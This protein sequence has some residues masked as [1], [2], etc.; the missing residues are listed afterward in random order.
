MLAAFSALLPVLST[1]AENPVTAPGASPE[2]SSLPDIATP[3]R[4]GGATIVPGANGVSFEGRSNWAKVVVSPEYSSQTQLGLNVGA[5]VRLGESAALG[6]LL[7]GGERKSEV[8]FNAGFDL[9]P[10]QR[11]IFSFGQLRQNLEYDFVSGAD[12]ARMTQNSG[13]ISYQYLLG[14]SLLKQVELTAYIAD[15]RSRDLTDKTYSVDTATVYELWNDP[16]RIAGGRVSGLQGRIG[17][18][19]L[20]GSNVKLSLG[21][22]R[23]VYDLLAG[24]DKTTRLTGGIEWAQQL[25]AGYQWMV[26]A[27][28]FAA[29][30]HYNLG[31]ERRL[32]DGQQIGLAFTG[33]QGRDGA[34]DDNR[35]QLTWSIGFGATGSRPAGT[36]LPSG[37][38]AGTA[39]PGQAN[40]LLDQVAR[41]PTFLPSQVIAK[42]DMSATPTRLVAIDKVGLPA[43][44]SIGASGDIS[45]PLGVAVTAISSI[46]RNAAAFTNSGQFALSGNNLIVRP[47]QMIQPA[48]GVP[49]SYV[50]TIANQDG[51]TTLVTVSA[52][53]GSV[54]IDSVVVTQV[55]GDSTAPSLTSTANLGAANIGQTVSHT[56]T[57]DEAI[58]AVSV[59]TVPTGM[60]V[61]ATRSGSSVT[62]QIVTTASFTAF[63]SVMIPVTVSDGVPN[64]RTVNV[65]KA[66]S[67]LAL[68]AGGAF[69]GLGDMTVS[70]ASGNSMLTINAGGVTDPLGRTITYSASG[71]FKAVGDPDNYFWNGGLTIDST[72]GTI[73]G[74]YD[75]FGNKV[76]NVTVTATNGSSSISKSFV[77]T[78]RDDG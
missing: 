9:D 25:G 49:D 48:A 13:G 6:L 33:I 5:A 29:Q 73:T 40:S 55:G 16:R 15:T 70:D 52:S 47:S 59:G 61:T 65:T 76:F 30:N 7:S 31:I 17:L 24:D 23:L 60:T 38:P 3:A 62:L 44:S 75:A 54:R 77:L 28:S 32:S 69:S 14:Q 4:V 8:L 2:S 58:A 72:T 36:L 1:A 71:L 53:R 27:D 43:G 66:I 21:G 12:R 51:S 45:V 20:P 11:L 63:G 39:I 56:L 74:V 34:P 42:V 68:V 10:R 57:F 26:G 18:S 19:P 37:Q 50:V 67:D 64:S 35:V 46:T 22:E 41:R 78:V